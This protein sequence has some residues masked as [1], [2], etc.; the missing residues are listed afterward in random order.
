MFGIG[1]IR[2]SN[3]NFM[4]LVHRETSFPVNVA[5]AILFAVWPILY[6]AVAIL[7]VAL[8]LLDVTMAILEFCGNK[9]NLWFFRL[10]L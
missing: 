8:A 9:A 1:Q 6:V 4:P 2:I 10:D 3:L 5:V 7:D